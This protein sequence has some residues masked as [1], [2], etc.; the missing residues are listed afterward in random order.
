TYLNSD[1]KRKHLPSGKS[2]V[3][4][5]A[6]FD[7]SKTLVFEDN[8]TFA[9]T[10]SNGSTITINIEDMK[11]AA[12]L[13]FVTEISLDATFDDLSSWSYASRDNMIMA[14]ALRTLIND[15]K[16]NLFESNITE[17]TF[18]DLKIIKDTKF[19]KN[20]TEMIKRYCSKSNIKLAQ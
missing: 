2:C 10:G 6:G 5:T 18:T 4:V 12:Y 13:S 3:I 16:T 8:Y 1:N 17:V 9:Q 14:P 11:G 15:T 20:I 7:E 19:T